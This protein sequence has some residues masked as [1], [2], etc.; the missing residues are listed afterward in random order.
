V[1]FAAYLVGLGLAGATVAGAV[2]SR[3]LG[4][5]RS[6]WRLGAV[7]ALGLVGVLALLFALTVLVG[8][9]QWRPVAIT[10]LTGVAL[11]AVAVQLAGAG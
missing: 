9:D 11:L 4:A 5:G 7:G 2:R 8:T 10:G 1:L 3:D 6:A